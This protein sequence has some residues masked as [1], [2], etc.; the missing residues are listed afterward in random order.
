M[1]VTTAPILVS[2][3]DSEPFRIEADSSD[4]ASGAILSQQLPG[5]EKWHPV[6][7]YSKSLS[8]VERNYEIHDKEMLAI[9]HALE[10]WRH[11]LE[12]AH[13]PVEIWMDHKN[14]EY[15]MMAKKLNRR[16]ARWSLYLARFDFKLV[17]CPGYSMGKPDALSRR[18]DH[19]KGA[20]DNEDMVLLRPELIAVRA[21][22][23]LHLEGL[24]RDM[25]RE[26]NQRD[27]QEEPVT[28]AAKELR[29]ASSKTVRSA[30]WSE[31]D[32]V[33][34][35]RGK[36]Y[37]PR[38]SDLR[39]WVVSLCHDT[40]VARHPGRWKTLELVSRNYWWP[41][42]SRY[43]RQ[44]V[45]TCD[46]CLRTKPIRQAPVGELHSFR[47]PD[48]RWDTLSVDFVVELPLSSGHDTVMTVVD[49]VSKQAHFIPMHM[50]VTAEG[51]ARLF[52]YQVWKLHGLL[53]CVVSDRGPQFVARFTRELYRLLEIK[54]AS[55]TAWHPQTDGQTEHVNQELD[56]YLRLFVNKWQDDWYDLLPMAEFQHNNHVHSATQQPPFLLDTGH[57][58]RMGFE[59]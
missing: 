16:Q 11:F 19:G 38:N 24:E 30:E 10:E 49:S 28:K 37:V 44:Y 54:L 43:I 18:P 42:M 55:S 35:F 22:E 39:R 27:E 2:P 32:G 56:Q 36:I 1:A 3:Q 41:Q 5:K 13:Y 26:M 25:L 47:I 23:G 21:L 33:L 40:K 46:L 59:P 9:I 14:L 8:P 45:S 7:F 12:G 58:P 50:T 51:A 48:L 4:F 31:E 15:F 20:S 29:Q 17:H 53:K 57:I 52:L 6:A 34:Q